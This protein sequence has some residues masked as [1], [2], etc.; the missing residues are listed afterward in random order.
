MKICVLGQISIRGHSRSYFK[1]Y[2]IWVN[3]I[4][5]ISKW[6]Y[7]ND[8]FDVQFSKISV[9]RSPEVILGLRLYFKLDIRSGIIYIS[10]MS[11]R[12]KKLAF[13]LSE[14]A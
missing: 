9:A 13:M 3:Y 4:T 2:V 10:K 8:A 14:V 6:V 7:Q 11:E 1:I 12:Q 5:I